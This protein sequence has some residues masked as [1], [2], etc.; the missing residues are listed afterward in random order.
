MRRSTR[1]W[2]T[3][4]LLVLVFYPMGK[5]ATTTTPVP[6]PPVLCRPCRCR[7]SRCRRRARSPEPSPR[8]LSRRRP[9]RRRPCH[10]RDADRAVADRVANGGRGREALAESHG[11]PSISPPCASNRRRNPRQGWRR[12]SGSRR[13]G[14]TER[15]RRAR[16]R[17]GGVVCRVVAVD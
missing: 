7:P 2:T 3:G 15:G 10:C 1:A 11:W 9:C 4:G 14:E 6:S 16:G 17:G 8:H 13:G 12:V 5:R